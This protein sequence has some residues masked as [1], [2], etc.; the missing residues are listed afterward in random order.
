MFHFT[1][2]G[3][4]L[5][6]LI[7]PDEGSVLTDIH[8]YSFSI[9]TN[10]RGLTFRWHQLR[11]SSLASLRVNST[12][13]HPLHAIISNDFITYSYDY[14]LD[15]QW[16]CK[17]NIVLQNNAKNIRNG[18]CKKR[19]RPLGTKIVETQKK[20]QSISEYIECRRYMGSNGLLI[21]RSYVN[22]WGFGGMVK[23]QRLLAAA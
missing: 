20:K 21:W 1:W 10:S 9:F 15:W 12:G 4:S 19:C 14:C 2:W 6:C 22:G 17:R 18:L 8:R 7:L 23:R 11:I 16:S 5:S 3:V 13:S